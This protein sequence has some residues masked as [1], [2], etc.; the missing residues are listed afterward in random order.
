MGVEVADSVVGFG[1]CEDYVGA[2][3]G[4]AGEVGAVFLGGE[5]LDVFAFFGV[6]EL[7]GVVCAG[8]DEEV[9][10]VVEVEGCY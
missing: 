6:V 8:C 7:E 3:V 5:R 1:G 9:A 10:G 2:V 4:E